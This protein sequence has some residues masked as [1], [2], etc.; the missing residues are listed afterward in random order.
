MSDRRHGR[1]PA[2]IAAAVV[3]AGCL[4]PRG[5]VPLPAAGAHDDD[6]AGQ[7]ARASVQIRLDETTA[8][9]DAELVRTR[10]AAA[11]YYARGSRASAW[12][13]SAYAG[14]D[15]TL[16]GSVYGLD[17]SGGGMMYGFAFGRSGFGIGG[18][19]MPA[20]TDGGDAAIV[21][22]VTWRGDRGVPWPAGCAG[23]RVARAGG[24]VAGAVVFLANAP[25]RGERYDEDRWSS[26]RG[27]ISAD[28][29]ALWPAA[30]VVGPTP[31]VVDLEN[32]GPDALRFGL[33]GGALDLALEPG[34]RWRV[35]MTEAQIVRV[36]ADRRGPA[37]VLGQ[38]HDYHTV[39]DELGRFS[40]D[41]VPAGTYEL[42]VWYPPLVRALD[43]ERPVWTEPTTVR[44]RVTVG[45]TG[46]VRAAFALDPAP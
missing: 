44:R 19:A 28:A 6:G 31:G 3:I 45:A 9:L 5:D 10:A 23:A 20:Y 8:D 1:T 42:V 22:A 29:C 37:W 15:P 11:R 21:G 24:A 2:T 41:E 26:G 13:G 25:R 7:L 39:T 33:G 43:G 12:G 18:P 34:A 36:D 32:G 16:G 17:S 27:A 4:G 40:L 30:Q 38:P 35:P 46:T 14:F